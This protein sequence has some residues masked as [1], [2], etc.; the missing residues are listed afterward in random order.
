MSRSPEWFAWSAM[1]QRCTNPKHPK[2]K[3]YGAR[4]IT[5]CDRWMGTSANFIADMGPRPSPAHSLDRK[6]NNGPY[7]PDNCRWATRSQ[8]NA[9]RRH[10]HGEA[11]ACAKLNVKQVRIIRRA[12]ML[13]L[14][15]ES[16]AR[17]FSVGPRSMQR[18]LQRKTWK[19]A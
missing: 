9:N 6:D 4:G 8:Q 15:T 12:H 3:H 16:L 17:M 1:V 7:S 2:Y 5:V 13:G 18:L 10:P 11:I 19:H 14:G